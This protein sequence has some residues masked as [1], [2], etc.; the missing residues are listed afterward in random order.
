MCIVEGLT[1]AS[2]E[3][4]FAACGEYVEAAIF[5]NAKK[6]GDSLCLL[7]TRSK[8]S[9]ICD[10]ESMIKRTRVNSETRSVKLAA[11]MT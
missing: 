7:D 6:Q 8:A 3:V 1:I 10:H 5:D 9:V 4:T 2:T 11:I